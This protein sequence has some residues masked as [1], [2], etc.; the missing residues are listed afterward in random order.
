M[1][2]HKMK[3]EIDHYLSE[4]CGRCSLGGTPECK[5]HSWQDELKYL[6]RLVLDCGLTEELKWS[7]PCY[8]HQSKNILMITAFKNNCTLSFFKGSL[9]KDEQGIL[10]KPGENSQ[11]ARVLRFTQVDQISTLENVL[12]A[13]IYEAIEVEK[14]GLQV[15]LKKTAEFD[16]PEELQNKLDEDEAFKTAFEALTPGRQRGYMLHIA[17]AKQSKTRINRIEKCIPNI[18]KGKG[19]NER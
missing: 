17:Q 14:A 19:Y 1:K 2:R 3:A 8:T 4:G 16:M 18:Y 13:Y 5:V 11:V 6:R 15:K 12:K 10:E 7:M 9:L